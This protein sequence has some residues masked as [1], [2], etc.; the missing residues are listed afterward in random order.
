MNKEAVYAFET[1]LL[2]DDAARYQNL[3]PHRVISTDCLTAKCD[4]FHMND[5]K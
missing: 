3:T 2:G 5:E 1:S 4:S